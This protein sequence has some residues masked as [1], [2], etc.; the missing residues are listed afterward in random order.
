MA[1]DRSECVQGPAQFLMNQEGDCEV[2]F[3]LGIREPE[4]S[5][6]VRVDNFT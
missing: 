5:C 1:I 6:I 2:S 4:K 3:G